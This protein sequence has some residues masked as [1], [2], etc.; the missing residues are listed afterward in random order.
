MYIWTLN[1]GDGEKVVYIKFRDE[2]NEE[3]SVFS[4]TIIFQD[5]ESQELGERDI[6]KTTESSAVYLILNRERH[7]FPHIAVYQSW[8]YPDDFSTLKLVTPENLAQYIEGD[9]VPFRDGSMFRGTAQSL[10]GKDASAVFYVEDNQLR[11]IQS[12]DIYQTLFNDP[13][14]S[15]VTWVP[16]DLLTKFEY[17]L[18]TILDSSNTH[19]NGCLIK[20]AGSS[21]IY[22]LENGKKRQ[23]NS[24]GTLKDNGYAS[25]KI[26]TLDNSEIYE[27]GEGIHILAQN[28]VTPK[29]TPKTTAVGEGETTES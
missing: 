14:W 27:N 2:N 22:I 21:A 23:F 4:D 26:L 28:M 10:H 8:A 9:P 29:I 1:T 17:P 24:W 25:R 12:S 20:Y 11:A 19:P 5:G 13:D 7:V 18:G 6:V 16:D 15:L 3:S